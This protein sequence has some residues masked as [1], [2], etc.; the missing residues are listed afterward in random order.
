MSPALPCPV[1]SGNTKMPEFTE[2]VLGLQ[3]ST[4]TPAKNALHKEVVDEPRPA[5]TPDPFH[6]SYETAD[7]GLQHMDVSDDSCEELCNESLPGAISSS[8]VWLP[9]TLPDNN[10]AWQQKRK[11]NLEQ[12]Q[13]CRLPNEILLLI[14]NQLDGVTRQ[15]M[16]RTCGHFLELIADIELHHLRKAGGNPRQVF[17]RLG[18]RIQAP[19]TWTRMVFPLHD[20]N[21]VR[22]NKTT[23]TAV[24][25]LLARDEQ[26]NHHECTDCLS[27][28]KSG[29]LD[30]TL[31]WLMRPEWC[32]GCSENHPRLFFSATQRAAS[33]L[34]RICI[35]L[36]G[37]IPICAHKAVTH[38]A[39]QDMCSPQNHKTHQTGDDISGPFH[40][41]TCTHESHNS[42]EETYDSADTLSPAVR[43]R[44]QSGEA[45]FRWT[46]PAFDVDPEVPVAK[47]QIR[48]FLDHC[49]DHGN[50]PLCPHVRQDNS[51]L[52]LP[53]EPY[54]CACFDEDP[55]NQPSTITPTSHS[56]LREDWC[57]RCRA[58]KNPH[59]RGF[60]IPPENDNDPDHSWSRAGLPAH[61]YRCNL[62]PTDYFWIRQGLRRAYLTVRCLVS[63]RAPHPNSWNWLW[64]VDPD[65][66][67]LK[68][69]QK[70]RHVLWCP[71]QKCVTSK[72]GL[73]RLRWPEPKG[74]GHQ[75]YQPRT[76]IANKLTSEYT[77]W[78]LA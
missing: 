28:R 57:C 50:I 30:K 78:R 67:G 53:F 60:F 63:A 18:L 24:A 9:R 37:R 45:H 5:D 48:D 62:C 36:E 46:S 33:P 71:D 77:I 41:I 31:Q 39:V 70:L 43:I 44:L 14:R 56:C 19:L 8:C 26:T 16:R 3:K 66:W 27:N 52:M 55:D 21:A 35:G 76:D 68:R 59:R 23:R 25:A 12:S 13:L 47:Q 69:D 58:I 54:Q 20:S 51:K 2:G 22:L 4:V 38:A 17:S 64:R 29:R 15:I 42:L 11:Q 32:S 7:D 1:A 10:P 34:Q 72:R 61:T 65:S 74:H 40:Q 49:K 73:Q 75:L 6:K